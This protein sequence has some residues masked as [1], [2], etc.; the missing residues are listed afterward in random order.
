MTVI[1]RRDSLERIAKKSVNLARLDELVD[2]LIDLLLDK[3]QK[4]KDAWQDFGM[5]TPLIRIREKLIRV[6]TL[7]DGRPVL[8]QDEDVIAEL[9]DVMGYCLLAMLWMDGQEGETF[10]NIIDRLREAAQEDN[11]LRLD[12][13]P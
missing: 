7:I 10:Q 5:F 3:N 11:D 4:Y 2:E 9:M 12:I 8:I 1:V 6:E 13:N